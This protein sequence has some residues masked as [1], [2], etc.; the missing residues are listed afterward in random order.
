MIKN[1]FYVVHG[2]ELFK[3]RK[4]R[5]L[6]DIWSL[7]TRR[8]EEDMKKDTDRRIQERKESRKVKEKIKESR[9]KKKVQ[10]TAKQK[11]E[12]RLARMWADRVEVSGNP[13]MSV[14]VVRALK[15]R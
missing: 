9:R 8:K 5:K 6:S 13:A 4:Q 2:K 11:A 3:E 10:L 1:T 14:G 7:G 15:R 12:S